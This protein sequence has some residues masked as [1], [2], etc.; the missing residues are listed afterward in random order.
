MKVAQRRY[1]KGLLVTLLLSCWVSACSLEPAETLTI[2]PTFLVA[3]CPPEGTGGHPDWPLADSVIATLRTNGICNYAIPEY[4]DEQRLADGGGH[5]GPLAYVFA[6]PI[7]GT[8]TTHHAFDEGYLNVGI[9]DI[10]EGNPA[11]IPATYGALH[12]GPQISCLYVRHKHSMKRAAWHAAV[13]KPQGP[14]RQCSGGEVTSVSVTREHAGMGAASYASVARFIEIGQHWTA[15][16]IRCADG[17]CVLGVPP[18]MAI[19]PSAH[20]SAIAST[21]SPSV[22]WTIKGWFDDQRVS[23]PAPGLPHGLNRAHRASLI[24]DAALAAAKIPA[25]HAGWVR[26]ATVYMADP[27]PLPKYASTQ[28]DVGYGLVEGMNRI[29]LRAFVVN[30][31]TVWRAR[32]SN[33][34]MPLSA[35]SSGGLERRVKRTDHKAFEAHGIFVPPV[36]RWRWKD[37]DEEIWVACD[38]GCCL[39]ERGIH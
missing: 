10:R 29:D 8:H 14:N 15:I 28:V 23:V 18:Q 31:D 9:V 27:K 6:S 21:E 39:I 30:G 33:A 24:P 3:S 26:V 32:I 37:D 35:D 17:F 19:P 25:F 2:T 36:A 11:N 7:V 1:S 13:G 20:A 4:H 12:L 34:L 16:G 5:L 22:Q 38:A